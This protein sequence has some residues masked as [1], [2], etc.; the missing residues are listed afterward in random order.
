[1]AYPSFTFFLASQPP[2]PPSH[3][4][5]CFTHKTTLVMKICQPSGDK[6]YK[7][8]NFILPLVTVLVTSL[9]VQSVLLSASEPHV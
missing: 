2:P 9:S 8:E 6:E 3:P 4:I 1:M 7:Q 5:L